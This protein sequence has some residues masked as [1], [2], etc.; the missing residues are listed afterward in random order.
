[1]SAEKSLAIVL[2]TVEFSETSLVVTLL[3]EDFGKISALAKG[4]R[5][6][7]GPFEAALDLLAITRV[8]FLRK[9]S[10]SLDLLTEAKLERRFRAA[11][12]NLT[13]L[14]AGFYVAELLRELTDEHDPHPE[15]FR[16]AQSTLV[17]LDELAAR[18]GNPRLQPDLNHEIGRRVLHLE[19][20]ALRILGHLPSLEQCAGCG[21]S[22]IADGRVAFGLVAGGVLCQRCREGKRQVASINGPAIAAMRL[23]A[24]GSDR[25]QTAELPPAARGEVRGV[26][27]RYMCNLL[28]KR[29]KT[30][31]LIT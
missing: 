26:I 11:S 1:M 23:F 2:R 8:V 24:E 9:S 25:W 19:L 16:L 6:P 17:A 10:G 31:E 27:N 21:T 5:R 20:G 29:P 28:G 18:D 3:T 4:A 30:Q 22:V 7:K 12:R 14:N 13:A 15:L